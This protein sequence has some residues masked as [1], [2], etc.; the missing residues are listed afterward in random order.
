MVRDRRS[1]WFGRA[2]G[3]VDRRM[4]WDKLPWPLGFV[5]LA[6]LRGELRR[7]NLYD[8]DSTAPVR[9]AVP[10][11]PDERPV[12]VRTIDGTFNDL[13]DPAMGSVGCRF[14]RNVPLEHTHPEPQST[15]LTPNPRVV[16]RELLTRET[17]RPATTLNVLA[18]AWIQFEV[19]DW[20]S[21][22]KSD[23][24]TAWELELADGDP[25]PER[26]MRIPRARADPSHVD[27]RSPPTWTTGDSHWWDGSQIYGSTKQFATM[28]RSNE[29][30]KLAV[31]ADGLPPREHEAQLDLSDVAGN[32]WL[33]L[34]L[35]H[36]VFTLEH[37]AICDRLRQ[38]YSTWSDDQV[39]D[40]A[41]LINAA[42]MAKIH[43]VEWTPAVIAHPTTQRAM[44]VNWYG[45][46]GR[47]MRRHL[48][49]LRAGDILTGI[50][51]SSTD[52]HGV[53]YS[54]T[55]EFTAVYRM[56]PLLPDEFVFRSSADDSILE[57]RTFPEIDALH[58]R[59]RLEAL[60]MPHALYSLGVAHPGAIEL[61]NYPRFL[62]HL[63]RPDGTILDLAATDILR[64]RERG[65]PRY[66]QFR[67][68]FRLS[69][70]KTFEDLTPNV[71]WQEELRRVYDGDVDSVDLM[72]GLYAEKPPKGFGFSDT[73]F[74]VFILMASRRLKSDRFF[75][76]DYTP[77]VYTPEGLAWID[78]NS[79]VTILLRHFPQLEPALCRTDNAFAPWTRV[80]DQAA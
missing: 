4:R 23:W 59:A 52:H 34:G 43:T 58:T 39:Y 12:N 26:P 14:G 77:E 30:G 67:R 11:E 60:S 5:L 36:V 45:L 66:N 20:F 7:A 25:W 16:S 50:P 61:H 56:H 1:T 76:V 38:T 10:P 68:L 31:G 18:A 9:G 32:F 73:A 44:R 51:G 27:G 8:T 79:L 3:A 2:V 57:E 13:D 17:F 64:I 28:V 80:S 55:E 22:G 71:E 47:R 78:E 42:L 62:Q 21:H 33:G 40:R 48:G 35:L 41:R 15:L 19:H 6:G 69:P 63:E 24:E 65:V 53:P 72:I 70:A 37:N 75:T 49:S 29:G 46:L 54:L 74:R